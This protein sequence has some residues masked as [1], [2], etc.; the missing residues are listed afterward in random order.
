MLVPGALPQSK[1]VEAGTIAGSFSVTSTGEAV[2]SMPL[3]VVPGRAGM[4]PSLGI[5]YGSSADEGVLGLGLGISGLS[6]VSRCPKNLAQDGEIAAVR[7]QPG[8]ALCL[9]SLRLVPV[10][11]ASDKPVEFRTVPDTFSKIVADYA[12]GEG[13]DPARGPKRFQVFTKGGLILDYGSADSGQVLSKKGVVRAWLLTR[14][15]DRSGN[16]MSFTYRNDKDPAEGFTV[17]H[18]PLRIDY[19]GHELAPPSRAVVFEYSKREKA[20]TRTLFARGM[21]LKRSLRLEKIKMLAQGDALVREHRFAF[22]TAPA[23]KRTLLHQIEECAADQACRPPTRFTWHHGSG[24]GFVSMPT[25]LLDPESERATVMLADVTGD[26]LD[27]LVVGDVDVT[28]GSEQ[29]ITNFIVAPNK[30]QEIAPTFFDTSA[31]AHQLSLYDPPLPVFPERGTPLDYNHDGLSDLFVH[32]VHG[33]F[34]TWRVLLAQ[35]DH[36]FVMFDTGLSRPYSPLAAMPLSLAAPDAS[37]HLG[38]VSGDGMPDL[39]ECVFNGVNHSWSLH[40]WKPEGPGFDKAPGMIPEL[41]SY[42]C[43]AELHPIDID[44]DGKI[45]LLVYTVTETANGPI[46]GT[47]Y[48]ALSFEPSTGA[49]TRMSTGLPVTPTGGRLLFLDA[50]GDGLPDAVE[51][52]FQNRQPL[53]FFNTGRGFRDA[54]SSLPAPMIDA[55]MFAK[56]AAVLDWNADGRQD[57]LMR[58]PCKA[59]EG[60]MT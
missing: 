47:T 57:L 14:Q 16:W 6:A 12:A 18:A 26:G 38:D 8:D 4:Q 22:T 33:Q 13:W 58:A 15:R 59:M 21:A 41:S 50:N 34:T 5:T 23:T 43:N 53:T 48:D 31:I 17:E 3:E 51:T 42:P 27:D 37:A 29:P 40:P 56:L 46:F 49:W 20:D 30:S 55:D 45:D 1:T 35:P 28:G 52:G 39:I 11:P 2:Y 36:T 7:D 9:D 54:V 60:P 25:P 32:D 24:P 44:I 10:E 19:T